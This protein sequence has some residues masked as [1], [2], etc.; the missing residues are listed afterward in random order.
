MFPGLS[1]AAVMGEVFL[2]F[3]A[4]VLNILYAWML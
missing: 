2:S 4:D 1:S 3:V